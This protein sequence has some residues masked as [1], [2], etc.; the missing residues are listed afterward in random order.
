VTTNNRKFL[1]LNEALR[2]ESEE[3]KK[4]AIIKKN[5]EMIMKIY[6]LLSRVLSKN[7]WGIYFK[8]EPIEGFPTQDGMRVYRVN[9]IAPDTLYDAIEQESIKA[10]KE[11]QEKQEG[12]TEK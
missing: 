11:W 10:E 12:R 3:E 5:E 7:E 6:E 9:E 8:G 1:S 2:C 4:R